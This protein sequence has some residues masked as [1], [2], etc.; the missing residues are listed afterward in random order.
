VTHC[1]DL[2]Y[3]IIKKKHREKFKFKL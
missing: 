1:R 2:S 3:Y